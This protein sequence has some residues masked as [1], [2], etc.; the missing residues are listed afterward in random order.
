MKIVHSAVGQ[1]GPTDIVGGLTRGRGHDRQRSDKKGCR[2][3]QN[4]V[5]FGVL[6]DNESWDRRRYVEWVLPL[7]SGIL[8][9]VPGYVKR[10]V[11][12]VETLV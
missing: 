8:S 6:R 9:T 2:S 12:G 1:S 11:G 10:M 4:N 7:V 5:S 3:H